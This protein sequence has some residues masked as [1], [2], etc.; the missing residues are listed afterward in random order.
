MQDVIVRGLNSLQWLKSTKISL[1]VLTSVSKYFK[2]CLCWLD[3]VVTIRT[4]YCGVMYSAKYWGKFT[5]AAAQAPLGFPIKETGTCHIKGGRL[6][7]FGHPGSMSPQHVQNRPEV[8]QESF[9]VSHSHVIGTIESSIRSLTWF[10]PWFRFREADLASESVN[11]LLNLT[12]VYHDVL[13]RRRLNKGKPKNFSQML[14]SEYTRFVFMFR[15]LSFAHILKGRYT[16]AW[17]A[18]DHTYN[19]A[20]ISLEI[21]KNLQLVTEMLLSRSNNRR[22][23]WGGIVVIEILK[24]VFSRCI[25]CSS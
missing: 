5:G 22:A 19:H 18:T 8:T 10:L 25:R 16:S 2:D 23:V 6:R 13:I 9:V 15:A 14:Q 17:C 24:C 7:L 12:G 1:L 21:I 4:Y 20:A 3:S 11:A